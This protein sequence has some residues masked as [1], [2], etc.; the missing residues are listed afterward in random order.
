CDYWTPRA[1][2]IFRS[3]DREMA[4]VR[5]NE[6]AVKGQVRMSRRRWG[7]GYFTI[8]TPA[9][10]PSATK[11]IAFRS[12]YVHVSVG[13]AGFQLLDDLQRYRDT[14]ND[15]FRMVGAY[16]PHDNVYE[17]LKRKPGV[18]V[19]RGSGIVAIRVLQRIYDDRKLHG[20]QTRVIH[21][22]RN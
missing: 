16:E 18:V 11:R 8:L 3:I 7:G 14:Y 2:Q 19:L 21:L 12:T 1:G 6:M 10:G 22:F 5:W 20:A 9:E 15:Y 13:Y 17:E 4:R